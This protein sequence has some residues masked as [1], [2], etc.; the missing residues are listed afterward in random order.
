MLEWFAILNRCDHFLL[1][2]NAHMSVSIEW[3]VCS[4]TFTSARFFSCYHIKTSWSLPRHGL[5]WP[6]TY[7][8]GNWSVLTL[9][10]LWVFSCKA[11]GYRAL[12][13]RSTSWKPHTDT[14]GE[15]GYSW[16]WY[17]CWGCTA[18]LPACLWVEFSR[19]INLHEVREWVIRFDFRPLHPHTCHDPLFTFCGMS[20]DR[21]HDT[22]H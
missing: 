8:K 22:D 20:H 16:F 1:F 7:M 4:L 18:C 12:S 14:W 19:V 10:Y 9:F 13:C 11:I 3:F 15:V 6:R 2:Y 21:S 17:V 5:E